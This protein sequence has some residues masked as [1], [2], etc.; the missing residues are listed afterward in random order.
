MIFM[1]PSKANASAD[2]INKKENNP[3][4]LAFCPRFKESFSFIKA[5]SFNS[6][7]VF[8]MLTLNTMNPDLL[9]KEIYR[10]H[11]IVLHG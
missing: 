11:Y 4:L 8:I 10:K 3:H 9:G 6:T 7:K 5:Q 2:P 1:D